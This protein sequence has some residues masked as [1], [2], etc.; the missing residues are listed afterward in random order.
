M[1]TKSTYGRDFLYQIVNLKWREIAT[2]YRDSNSAMYKP[3]AAVYVKADSSKITTIFILS[4][5][6][7]Q[8][9]LKIPWR[10]KIVGLYSLLMITH[11]T[12]NNHV[13]SACLYILKSH[14]V[15]LFN[16]VNRTK[17]CQH[18]RRKLFRHKRGEPLQ[19]FADCYPSPPSSFLKAHILRLKHLNW[20]NS[21]L[22][23]RKR[24]NT[25]SKLIFSSQLRF[26]F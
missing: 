7:I 26:I 4:Q 23:L 17:S 8:P 11:S 12:C 16:S 25:N 5:F 3:F 18:V 14:Y 21:T 1:T 10:R 24:F 15:S 6:W 19:L 2:G 9:Q 20:V 22:S 13:F